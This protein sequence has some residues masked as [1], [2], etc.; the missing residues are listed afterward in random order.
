SSHVEGLVYYDSEVENVGGES[1]NRASNYNSHRPPSPNRRSPSPN[2]RSSN[3]RPSPNNQRS[4][5]PIRP[6][7]PSSGTRNKQT[8]AF[9]N[10][11]ENMNIIDPIVDDEDDNVPLGLYKTTHITK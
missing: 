6:L 3:V 7:S 2:G 4:T 10:H 9:S 1:S 11:K 5:S 8:P